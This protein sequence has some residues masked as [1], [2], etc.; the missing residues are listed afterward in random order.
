MGA[1]LDRN[2]AVTGQAFW[3]WV[4]LCLGGWVAAVWLLAAWNDH[5]DQLEQ[6][7]FPYRDDDEVDR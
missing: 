3:I 1:R 2:G 7:R 5:D 4:L 6:Y